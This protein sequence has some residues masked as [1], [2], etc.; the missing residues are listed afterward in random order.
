MSCPC[1]GKAVCDPGVPG[2]TSAGSLRRS[3]GWAGGESFVWGQ[4][5]SS[6]QPALFLCAATDTL[7]DSDSASAGSAASAG[8]PPSSRQPATAFNGVRNEVAPGDRARAP[9]SRWSLG[10]PAICWPA[11]LPASGSPPE[12]PS[13]P[14]KRPASTPPMA[15]RLTKSHIRLM[16]AGYLRRKGTVVG[17]AFA[18]VLSYS[19]CGTAAASLGRCHQV[20]DAHGGGGPTIGLGQRRH[21]VQ[22]HALCRQ[23]R[24]ERRLDEVCVL[25][26]QFVPPVDGFTAVCCVS[27][28][29]RVVAGGKDRRVL[30][31]RPVTST[32]AQQRWR[33]PP[34]RAP[35]IRGSGC[36]QSR[37]PRS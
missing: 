22:M 14:P 12:S 10:Y 37:R 15:L 35:Q 24:L 30:R 7:T 31:R 11:E 25:T 36:W 2:A 8:R 18:R 20:V 9:N 5:A 21:L 33:R 29:T 34:S 1:S 28:S 17:R 32:G 16:K 3:G 26:V 6:K 4:Q 13:S 27:P 19:R 23:E